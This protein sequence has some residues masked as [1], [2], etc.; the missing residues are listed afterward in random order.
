MIDRHNK[1][2]ERMNGEE[3]PDELPEEL[4]KPPF[5]LKDFLQ[6]DIKPVEYFV[7][8]ILPKKGR[9]MITA[10]TNTGKSIFAQNMALSLT[11][12]SKSFLNQAV[13][14]ASV[15]YLDFEMGDSALKDR[16]ETMTKDR[17]QPENLY[18]KHLSDFDILN[19]NHQEKFNSWISNLKVDVVI[20]DPIGSAWLGDENDKLAVSEVT[21]FLNTLIDKFGLSIVI[22]HHW[23]KST[24]DNSGG[25]EMAAGSYKWGAWVDNHFT[26]AGEINSLTVSCEKAR[27]GSR[28]KPF[29]IRLN[30]DPCLFEFLTNYE[31]KFTDQIIVSMFED[32]GKVEVT[33]Q[34][35]I[36]FSKANKGPCA[37]KIDDLVK[38]S[39][40]FEKIGKG[41]NMRIKYIKPNN[42]PLFESEEEIQWEE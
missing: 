34:E 7:N 42:P 15:L 18:I 19:D 17:L 25:G 30:E 36:E 39:S 35:L 29:L 40:L 38:V 26:L 4:L 37:S 13:N 3:M 6:Q 1:F 21:R 5:S 20:L 27:H 28:I 14:P 9:L 2:I 22:V 11:N 23:R 31:T 10:K 41:K 8:G 12:G 24:K 33:R 16:F 32:I